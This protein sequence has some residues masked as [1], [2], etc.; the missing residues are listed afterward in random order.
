[1]TLPATRKVS[2]MSARVVVPR[3][4]L[5]PDIEP[6]SLLPTPRDEKRVFL[7]PEQ[8]AELEDTADFHS[9]AYAEMGIKGAVS[10]N[11]L[12]EG[13][14]TWALDA[15]WTDK[16]GRPK[17]VADRKKKVALFAEQLKAKLATKTNDDSQS[18]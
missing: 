12:V 15:F 14:L 8:W 7:K 2:T 4:S 9:E 10:R 16:G 13:F 5:P 18:R 17:N 3:T 11:D 1:M 6:P